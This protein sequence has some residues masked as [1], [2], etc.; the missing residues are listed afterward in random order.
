[1]LGRLW[2]DDNAGKFL[3]LIDADNRLA[4]QEIFSRDG[5][6][7]SLEQLAK[8]TLVEQHK[9]NINRGH[10]Y[11]ISTKPFPIKASDKGKPDTANKIDTNEIPGIGVCS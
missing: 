5:K 2:R 7:I 9:D 6:T 8:W 4:L 3:N 1:M 10:I 11:I